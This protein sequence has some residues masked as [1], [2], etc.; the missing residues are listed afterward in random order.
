MEIGAADKLP[1]NI[2]NLL[3]LHENLIKNNV[4]RYIY[5]LR[6]KQSILS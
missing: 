6:S 2:G 4:Q 1:H 5:L 3:L